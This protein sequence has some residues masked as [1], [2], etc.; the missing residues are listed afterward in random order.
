[1]LTNLFY[2]IGFLCIINFEKAFSQNKKDQ[3]L[4]D[5]GEDFDKHIKELVK[6]SN[7]TAE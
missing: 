7:L 1:M 3:K 4:I 5:R 2:M 6:K